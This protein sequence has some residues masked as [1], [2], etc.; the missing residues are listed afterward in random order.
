[1]TFTGFCDEPQVEKIGN[2]PDIVG[3]IVLGVWTS[4]PCN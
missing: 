2:F 3:K 4:L 1:V